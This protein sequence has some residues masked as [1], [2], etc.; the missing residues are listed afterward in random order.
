MK[1]W[2]NKLDY[3]CLD[4]ETKKAWKKINSMNRMKLLGFKKVLEADPVDT[5]KYMQFSDYL[6]NNNLCVSM[7]PDGATI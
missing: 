4:C 6:N 7:I 3:D 2:C 5:E 1:C